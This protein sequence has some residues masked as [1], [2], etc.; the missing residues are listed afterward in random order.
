MVQTDASTSVERTSC[1]TTLSPRRCGSPPAAPACWCPNATCS[2]PPTV[3]TTGRTTSRGARK[4]RVGFLTPPYING[5]RPGQKNSDPKKPLVRWVRVR[6]TRV[7]KGWIQGPQEVSMD[8][9]YALLE[10]RWPH[11][12]PFMRLAVAPSSD[13]L[14]G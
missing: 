3:S 9:D 13:D 10:L 1:W 11:R 2:P 12:Q 14:A 6:R 8:F 4:L 7:P 5:T